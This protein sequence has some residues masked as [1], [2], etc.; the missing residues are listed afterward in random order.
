VRHD[1]S[2]PGFDDVSED[3][4]LIS[5]VPEWLEKEELRLFLIGREISTFDKEAVFPLFVLYL[6]AGFL[7]LLLERRCDR[8][9][10]DPGKHR[11][12]SEFLIF[13]GIA[14]RCTPVAA[15]SS[16]RFYRPSKKHLSIEECCLLDVTPRGSWRTGVLEESISSIISVTRIG[17]LGTTLAVTSI[18][19]KLRRNTMC[20]RC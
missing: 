11:T 8:D 15:L 3:T 6:T 1:L 17:E 18:R 7:F 13:E 2:I 16:L 20:F 14:S 5:S 4:T 19:S 9:W 10:L 12:P